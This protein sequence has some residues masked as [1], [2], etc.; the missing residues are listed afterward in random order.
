MSRALPAMRCFRVTP[1]SN[2]M[3]MK[4]CSPCLPIS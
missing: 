3:A 1:S 2:S 4:D